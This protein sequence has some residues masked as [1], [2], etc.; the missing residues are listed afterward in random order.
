MEA[1]HKLIANPNVYSIE[2]L[3]REYQEQLIKSS[4]DSIYDITTIGSPQKI[5]SDFC[6]SC[7]YYPDSLVSEDNVIV[8]LFQQDAA[9]GTFAKAAFDDFCKFKINQNDVDGLIYIVKRRFVDQENNKVENVRYTLDI[10]QRY[11]RQQLP[12]S[13]DKSWRGSLTGSMTRADLIPGKYNENG[14]DVY[15]IPALWTKDEKPSIIV[16]PN[17]EQYSVVGIY[18]PRQLKRGEYCYLT[19]G[20]VLWGNNLP[21][22]S[23]Y[24]NGNYLAKNVFINSHPQFIYPLQ[25]DF[26]WSRP[27]AEQIGSYMNHRMDTARNKAECEAISTSNATVTLSLQMTKNLVHAI[28]D[29]TKEGNVAVVVADGVGRVKALVDHRKPCYVINPNDSRR[30]QFVEDSLKREGMLNRGHEAER[31]FGNKAILSLNFGPGSSQKPLVWTAVTSQYMGWDWN[32]LQMAKIN[33]N[34]MHKGAKI[35]CMEL[36]WPTYRPKERTT[37]G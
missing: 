3:F 9:Y 13:I 6:A 21:N 12:K 31:F 24:G 30:I 1:T 28:D 19:D 25:S 29:V 36:C 4:K 22:L 26:Y 14:M 11:F 18:E 7:D 37:F 2:A 23:K 17:T 35:P 27:L 15:T 33:N 20:E 8:R 32:L 16:K 5:F 34:L 10:T